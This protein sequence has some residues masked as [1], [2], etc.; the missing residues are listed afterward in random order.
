MQELNAKPDGHRFVP[1][2]HDVFVHEEQVDKEKDN[3]GKMSVF[4][5]M[6][7]FETDMKELI[8]KKMKDLDEKKVVQIFADC[9]QAI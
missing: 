6:E 8:Q 4:M 2:L 5:V 7:Y 9:L 1:I 3:V